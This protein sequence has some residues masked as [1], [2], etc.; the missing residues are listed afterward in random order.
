MKL[1]YTT[2]ALLLFTT[3]G[4]AQDNWKLIYENDAEGNAI[5]GTLDVLISSIQ[6][7]EN[8]RIYFKM[9]RPD[10]SKTSVEHTALV[11]F[12][13]VIHSQKGKFVT[14]QIDTIVG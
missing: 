11:K 1:F 5:V 6:K 14:A 12:T 3:Y 10:Q 2:I 8:I 9:E 13:T 4:V 7:G